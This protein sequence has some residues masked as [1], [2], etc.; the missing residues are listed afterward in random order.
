MRSRDGCAKASRL[1]FNL[2]LESKKA[3]ARK[4]DQGCFRIFSTG[5]CIL[6]RSEFM[7]RKIRYVGFIDR[8]IY[9][10]IDGFLISLISLTIIGL[11]A[12]YVSGSELNIWLEVSFPIHFIFITAFLYI[13]KATPSMMYYHHQLVSQK[14]MG[15]ATIFQ[16]IIRYFVAYLS[17][18]LCGLGYLWILMDRKNRTWH[19]I[20]SGTIV[21]YPWA[22]APKDLAFARKIVAKAHGVPVS[23]LNPKNPP[24]NPIQK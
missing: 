2:G 3:R 10:N 14:T 6:K 7:P 12:Y 9:L 17:F 21:I 5:R 11:Y 13:K 1:K 24:T 20:A 15:R 22:D 18:L 19:E 4:L 16:L 23:A 8:L